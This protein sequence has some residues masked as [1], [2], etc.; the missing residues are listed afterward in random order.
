MPS[1]E[2]NRL[3]K[4]I[5]HID[6]LPEDAS[7]YATWI[8][9]G[10]H[11]GLLR[12]NAHE[13]EL[14]IYASDRYT[15]IHAVTVSE[16]SLSSATPN[17]LLDWHGNPFRYAAAS[18]TW[19]GGRSE[20]WIDRSKDTW[21]SKALEGEGQQLVFARGLEGD[22]D[23]LYYEILQEY[24]HLADIHWRSGER[25]YCRFD[26]LGDIEHV[27]SITSKD[28]A[29]GLTLVSFKREQLEQYLAASQSVLIRMFDFTLYQSPFSGWLD[30][31]EKEFT[32]G[33]SLIYRQ[34]IDNQ[35]ASYTRGIQ[36]VRP[37]RSKSAIF[38]QITNGWGQ[39]LLREDEYCEFI[40][41]D[42][43]NKRITNISTNPSAI[44]SYFDAQENSLPFET[45]PV[46]FRP[47][48]LSKYKTDRD[49]YTINEEHRYISCRGGWD[50]RTYDVNEAGQIHTYICYLAQLPF[51]EQLH[52]KSFNEEPKAGI[53]QRAF[54]NDF[55]AEFSDDIDP[56]VEILFILKEWD[57]ANVA[58]WVIQD[59]ALL[60]RVN[61]PLTS[62]RD[63]WGRAFLDFSQLVIEGFKV[64]EIR[65]KLTE[66]GISFEKSERSLKL[67]E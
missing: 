24:L 21:R 20:V 40:A 2:H 62:S 37:S 9:A 35:K 55:K 31:G 44:T 8:N 25:A 42:W 6:V 23:S 14:V 45:S 63:E 53:S 34:K 13:D 54:L 50:L 17:D 32:E 3:V 33:N 57:D 43:R 51:E 61:T 11:L 29:R 12:E 52:W 47:E 10:L 5:T 48:V 7:E 66:M 46:F 22:P 27:V 41:W 58:W 4:R 39:D 26:E 65:S 1:Y 59:K 49:K 30:G 38:A 36:I 56:L 18:Y 28:D 67:V 60:T 19:G 16:K 64:R 15:F